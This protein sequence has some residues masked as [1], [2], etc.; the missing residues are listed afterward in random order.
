MNNIN[1]KP[2]IA[3]IG[4]GKMG[5]EIEKVAKDT[6]FVITDIFEI[7]NPIIPEK[8]YEF[9]VAIEFT[10]PESTIE[11][12]IKIS[13]IKKNIVVGTTGWYEKIDLVKKI[14]EDSG[15]GLI[16]SPNFSVG[17]QIILK[18]IEDVSNILNQINNYDIIIEETHHRHK[19]DV[20]SGTA[21]K[22]AEKIL[23]NFKAKEKIVTNPKDLDSK[24][25]QI[26]SMRLGEVYGIHKVILDSEFDTLEFTHSAKTRKGFAIGALLAAEQ[27]YGKKGFFEFSL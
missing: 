8:N 9:D 3:L 20:P 17:I 6:G 23:Q 16:Y 15:I 11:N 25:I 12:I 22:I 4:Y 18:L 27:I 14:V 13:R 5:K 7:D 24:S 10:N 19:K 26:A 2:K 1:C 21:L